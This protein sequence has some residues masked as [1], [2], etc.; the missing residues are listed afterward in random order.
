MKCLWISE[1]VCEKWGEKILSI[2]GKRIIIVIPPKSGNGLTI[3]L[4]CL[5]AETIG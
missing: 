3:R 4:K 5:G 1:S 2:E